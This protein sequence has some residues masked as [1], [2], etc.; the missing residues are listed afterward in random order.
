MWR[1]GHQA[2]LFAAKSTCRRELI[3]QR[4]TRGLCSTAPLCNVANIVFLQYDFSVRLF[5]HLTQL[6]HSGLNLFCWK[7]IGYALHYE[8]YLH[9][10]RR[11]W[12]CSIV[13]HQVQGLF[14]KI[15]LKGLFLYFEDDANASACLETDVVVDSECSKRAMKSFSFMSYSSSSWKTPLSFHVLLSEKDR[16]LDSCNR[17]QQNFLR[18]ALA[19]GPVGDL[20]LSLIH[21]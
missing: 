2:P 16:G 18:V 11:P 4:E 21:I 6:F 9:S 5:A 19:V 13:L 8:Q 3:A 14:D 15:L 20:R 10:T 1:P 12:S 17:H 7:I